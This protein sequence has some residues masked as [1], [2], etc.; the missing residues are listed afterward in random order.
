MSAASGG[1]EQ[2]VEMSK[3]KSLG[4]AIEQ[5]SP[6]TEAQGQHSVNIS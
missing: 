3:P 6:K 1:W 2:E 4:R 5:L